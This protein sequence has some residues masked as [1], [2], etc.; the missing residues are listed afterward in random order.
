MSKQARKALQ[1]SNAPQPPMN[2]CN[3]TWTSIVRSVD[4]VGAVSVKRYEWDRTSLQPYSKSR[5]LYGERKFSKPHPAKPPAISF[6]DLSP[7]LRNKIYELALVLDPAYVEL[8]AKTTVFWEGNEKAREHHLKR[9]KYDIQRR[10]RFLRVCKQVYEEAS[11][12]FYGQN[13]FRFTSV[14]GCPR[15]QIQRRTRVLDMQLTILTEMGL[16]PRK[17]W[18]QFNQLASV[19]RVKQILENHATLKSF[20]LVIPDSFHPVYETHVYNYDG[21]FSD[22]GFVLDKRKF[23][24]L[25]IK[26]ITLQGKLRCAV[27]RSDRSGLRASFSLGYTSS[28]PPYG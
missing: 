11:P 24:G 9:Y 25:Q 21:G 12:I 18:K 13:E 6:L 14:K 20:N 28:N 7:E 3:G 22:S 19:K 23:E 2:V 8:S 1:D 27:G 15:L 5:K 17:G 26:L 10:L 4:P 16:K